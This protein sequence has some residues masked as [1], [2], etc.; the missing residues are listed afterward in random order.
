MNALRKS[1]IGADCG[2]FPL[3]EPVKMLIV[4]QTT[5]SAWAMKSFNSKLLL[6]R[7]FETILCVNIHTHTLVY[8]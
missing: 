6:D 3:A 1:L 8:I 5:G 4:S 7:L 2:S